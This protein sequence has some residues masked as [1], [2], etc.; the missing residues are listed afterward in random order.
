M[1]RKEIVLEEI[2]DEEFCLLLPSR[3]GRIKITPAKERYYK[4]ISY[5]VFD[6][7]GLLSQ[8]LKEEHVNSV[9]LN[10]DVSKSLAINRIYIKRFL[11]DKTLQNEFIEQ[12]QQYGVVVGYGRSANKGR[13]RGNIIFIPTDRGIVP[14]NCRIPPQQLMHYSW[15]TEPS[16]YTLSW[17]VNPDLS[18][19]Q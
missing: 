7:P 1:N 10:L 13:K 4:M 2:T 14:A 12:V 6:P 11:K 9:V 18:E 15:K 17:A 19:K 16:A 3:F 8:V 5:P